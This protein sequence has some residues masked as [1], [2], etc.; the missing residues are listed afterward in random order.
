[1]TKPLRPEDRRPARLNALPKLPIF[2]DLAG[3]S[4]LVVGGSDGIAWKAELLAA[5]GGTVRILAAEPSPELLALVRGNPERLTLTRRGWREVDLERVSVAVA[6]IEDRQEAQLFAD[7]ARRHGAIVNIVDQPAFCDFQFG[8]IVNRAPV[9]VSISTDGAAPILGQAIR[10]RIEAVL[11]P[12]LG[13]WAQAAKGFRDRLR[14]IVPSKSGRRRF[15]EKFVDVTFISQAQEDEQLAEIERLA[16]K[17]LL[18]EDERPPVGEVIIV[19]AGPGDPEL[20]TL[21]AMRELQAADIIVYD[22]LVTP[23]VLELSRREARRIHVGKEGHGASCR[24][25]DINALIV[26]LALAGERV[27]RLKGGDPAIFGRTGEEVAACRDA[28]VPVRI[29]PGITSASAAAALLNGSLTHRD[30]AQRVQ[31]VTAHDR[32]GG[33][34]ENLNI[35]ALADPQA[36]TVVYMGRRT[37]SKLATRLIE[38]GLPSDTPVAAVSNVSR[39]NQKSLHTTIM[40]VA[41]GVSLPEDGPVIIMIGAS[42][43]A[44]GEVVVQRETASYHRDEMRP[45][46][47]G[48]E[49]TLSS[50]VSQ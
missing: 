2:F 10:R 31:F 46:R 21:K 41:R 44:A 49:R 16:R 6:D 4:I 5:A 36:T 8:T 15:W 19:G 48:A 40:D 35:G 12:S 45:C 42:V 26:D 47:I 25:E 29:V 17:T 13:A 22:R 3:R 39:D 27:V 20:L 14:E 37:A 38:G 1:M 30:H 43:G 32:H 9:I 34:P 23:G 11:P 28:G 24:Q 18:E 33:L 7:A 50:L